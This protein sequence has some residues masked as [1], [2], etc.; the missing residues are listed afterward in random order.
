MTAPQTLFYP[1]SENGKRSVAADGFA[2]RQAPVVR[3]DNLLQVEGRLEDGVLI[4][5][6]LPVVDEGL[7]L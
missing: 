4:H 7:E 6:L 3:S 2:L 5:E 1:Q